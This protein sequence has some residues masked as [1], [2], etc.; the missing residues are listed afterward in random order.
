VREGDS[1]QDAIYEFDHELLH[2]GDDPSLWTRK[3]GDG[4][5]EF[6]VEYLEHN[7]E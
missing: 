5:A 1:F 6:L 3:I 2:K 4:L 7:V